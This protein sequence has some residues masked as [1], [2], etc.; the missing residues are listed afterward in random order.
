MPPRL[1]VDFPELRSTLPAVTPVG[2]GPVDRIRVAVNRVNPLVTRAVIDLKYPAAHRVEAAENGVVI[3]FEDEA[4]RPRAPETATE[5]RPV[6]RAEAKAAP[7]PV[8]TPDAPAEPAAGP[9]PVI[10]IAAAEPKP[11]A[12]E[13]GAE[14]GAGSAADETRAPKPAAL[15]VAG[16]RQYTGHLIT[17]DFYQA[18]LRSV[19]RTFSE[20]SGLNIVI[21]PAVPAG[22]VDVSLREVPWDQAL[23]VILRSHQLG[24][25]LEQNVV[26]I[27]PLKS[28][29][30]EEGERQKLVEAQAMSGQLKV[31]TKTLSYARA[32]DVAKLLKDTRVLS[33]RG[34]ALVDDRTNTLIINDLP[35][36][37]AESESLIGILDRSEPQVEIEAKIVQTGTDTARALGVQ[38]GLN[39]RMATELGNTAPVAFPAQSALSGRTTSTQGNP[40]GPARSSV[41]SAV[42]LP[43]TGATSALG[44]SMGTL[45]GSFSLDVALDGPRAEGAGQDP[46][47]AQG[48]D[49]EQLRSGDDAGRPDSD[50][51]R[52]E[53]HRHGHVQGRGAHAEG[54]AADHRVE[55]RDDEHHARERV[56]RLQPVGQRHSADRHAAGHHAGARQ[57]RRDDGHRRHHEVAGDLR[58]GRRARDLADPAARLAVPPGHVRRGTARTADLHHAAHPALGHRNVAGDTA[59]L[60]S[61][62]RGTGGWRWAAAGVV[63]LASAGAVGCGQQNTEGRSPSYLLIDTPPGG[64]GRDAGGLRRHARL[65]RGHQRQRH[66]RRPGGAVAHRLRGPRAGQ[67]PDGAQG[68]RQRHGGGGADAGQFR[69]RHPL[70]RRVQAV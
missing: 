63:V 2:Q 7:A 51:D 42:N 29:A 18:E 61:W 9:Q 25:V 69:H 24:Y 45:S 35:E 58:E 14:A 34:S 49:A 67:A 13:P 40:M 31:F 33:N 46:V 4:P 22:T 38:W 21:D 57:R 50:S 70:P 59:M 52:L 66:G 26:R 32:G 41:P 15:A 30:A 60:A 17:F 3:V 53:Q 11:P 48:H 1:V 16:E 39:G 19:L 20:I 36:A 12:A 62:L 54:E 6:A 27:A 5:P 64:V 65:G 55:H 10:V 56:A 43:A 37:I 44:L 23:E 47:A 28:L 8:P 68:R